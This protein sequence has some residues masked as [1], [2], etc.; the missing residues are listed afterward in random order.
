MRRGVGVSGGDYVQLTGPCER[1]NYELAAIAGA[2]D[3]RASIA[4][5]QKRED[6]DPSRLLALGAS[7]G[8]LVVTALTIDPPKGLLAA[9]SFA[10]GQ[11]SVRDGKLCERGPD[12]LV[13]TFKA[14]GKRSRSPMLWIYSENDSYFPSEFS[15]KFKEAFSAGGGKVEL[16][17][18]PPFRSDGHALI[19]W[20]IPQWTPY[21]DEFL[22][23]RGL[24]QLET[25][26]PLPFVIAP[27]Q[28]L[29]AQGRKLF[30]DFHYAPPHRALAISRTRG[31]IAWHGGMRTIEDTKKAA[32]GDC[33][34]HASDC[35]IVVV[36]DEAIPQPPLPDIAPPKQLNADGRTSFEKF[37][38][39]PHHRA[40]AVSPTGSYGWRAGH[41]TV[42]EARK[43]ALEGC[44]KHASDC[45]IV[46]VDDKAAP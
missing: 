24:A 37:L 6:I 12:N 33:A 22:K 42:E 43:L 27:P 44:A 15:Q 34:K 4:F 39:S 16:I 10:G 18:A 14:L 1:P 40:F 20:G 23:Q 46:V 30:E 26:L 8:G 32:L 38:N 9:I 13:A 19:L 36:N 17:L 28:Q 45:V 21:I 2:S 35:R 7:A 5:L 29:S 25:P 41:S 3:L 11:R 31:A